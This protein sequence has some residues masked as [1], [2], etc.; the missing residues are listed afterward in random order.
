MRRRH[1]HVLQERWTKS[2]WPPVMRDAPFTGMPA[3]ERTHPTL[4]KVN[5]AILQGPRCNHDLAPMFRLPFLTEEMKRRVDELKERKR[6]LSDDAEIEQTLARSISDSIQLLVNHEY[7]AAD[8][9]TKDQPSANSLLH[10]LH[11]SL[12]THGRYAAERQEAGKSDEGEEGA[13][14][15]LQCFV[16]A[17]QQRLHKGFPSIF[18]SLHGK[19]TYYC[20]HTFESLSL[21]NVQ[22]EFDNL[23]NNHWLQLT[24]LTAATSSE[25]APTYWPDPRTPTQRR[26]DYRYRP[27]VMEAFSLYYFTSGTKQVATLHSKTWL[28][29]T[30]TDEEWSLHRRIKVA[31]AKE[32]VRRDHP[33]YRNGRDGRLWWR[34]S[35][36]KRPDGTSNVLVD[37]AGQIACSAD[38]YREIRYDEP[39]RVPQLYAHFPKTPTADSSAEARGRYGLFAM[40]LLRPWRAPAHALTDW[41]CEPIHLN[42]R[43]YDAACLWQELYEEFQR[44]QSSLRET[45]QAYRAS[46][47][48]ATSP[49]PPYRSEHS[50]GTV[51]R[52]FCRGVL[53]CTVPQFRY[54]RG[55][56][57]RKKN[58]GNPRNISK[59]PF[60]DLEPS[61]SIEAPSMPFR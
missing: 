60:V 52:R 28:W 15:L 8:Y 39:W 49:T 54:F 14:R 27:D 38:H 59:K 10:T 13:R 16:S 40:I 53:Q 50:I 23:L 3:L 25:R 17:T 32:E 29:H 56:G 61:T 20:S 42:G 45:L 1:G 37:A 2:R 24:P 19:P 41:L 31:Q 30:A 5:P 43:P 51:R 46:P 35:R 9:V 4:G 18:A 6:P 44:W 11:E 26:L 12:V 55:G 57:R 7:Y 58:P 22:E 34:S 33:C 47:A 48:A 21:H 36:S